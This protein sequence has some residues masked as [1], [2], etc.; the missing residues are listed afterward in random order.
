M[1]ED[2]R[3][4]LILLDSCGA[5]ELPD[6]FEYGERAS[7]SLLNTVKEIGGL[8]LSNLEGSGQGKIQPIKG[9][10]TQKKIPEPLMVEW[11]SYQLEKTAL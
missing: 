8:R 10:F 7:N 4:I 2:K 9:V 1:K 5:G 3:V 11:R 6:A